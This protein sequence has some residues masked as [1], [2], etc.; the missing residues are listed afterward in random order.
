MGVIL[1]IKIL[2]NKCWPKCFL[3]KVRLHRV[4]SD[5]F[6]VKLISC[7]PDHIFEK[8]RLLNTGLYKGKW[9]WTVFFSNFRRYLLISVSYTPNFF[10]ERKELIKADLPDTQN[11]CLGRIENF[12]QASEK[13]FYLQKWSQIEICSE[14]PNPVWR[15][16][17]SKSQLFSL[18]LRLNKIEVS[19]R[20]NFF[21]SE[22]S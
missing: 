14:I 11:I 6:D 9:I 22:K 19:H 8:I 7:T 21:T 10:Y 2:G 13:S 17:F 5:I 1:A 18:F 12:L 15:V 4:L 20:P 3:W 16:D